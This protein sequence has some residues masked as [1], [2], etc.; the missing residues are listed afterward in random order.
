MNGKLVF[1]HLQNTNK[2]NVSNLKSAY[3]LLES[4]GLKTKFM[5]Q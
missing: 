3:Y 4:D 5:K 2:I 1:T